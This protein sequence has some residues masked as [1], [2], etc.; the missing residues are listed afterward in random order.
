MHFILQMP[1]I[2]KLIFGIVILL[3][4]FIFLCYYIGKRNRKHENAIIQ[5]NLDR[6]LK[7]FE[8]RGESIWLR[9]TSWERS[10]GLPDEVIIKR[11]E[12]KTWAKDKEDLK[13]MMDAHKIKVTWIREFEIKTEHTSDNLNMN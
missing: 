3:I 9:N 2:I 5:A 13:Q 10:Q 12:G 7:C 1:E 6:G 8:W 4:T 11:E